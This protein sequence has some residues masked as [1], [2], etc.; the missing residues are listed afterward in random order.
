MDTETNDLKLKETLWGVPVGIFSRSIN[1]KSL[2]QSFEKAHE[3]ASKATRANCM[4]RCSDNKVLARHCLSAPPLLVLTGRSPKYIALVVVTAVVQSWNRKKSRLASV[5]SSS[6][7]VALGWFWGHS[8]QLSAS[9]FLQSP[10]L[11]HRLRL[12]CA[13]VPLASFLQLVRTKLQ[14]VVQRYVSGQKSTCLLKAIGKKRGLGDDYQH[15][16]AVVLL[17]HFLIL[18]KFD[19]EKFD[20]DDLHGCSLYVLCSIAAAAGGGGGSASSVMTAV[21]FHLAV[22]LCQVCNSTN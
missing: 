10:S 8:I 18:R 13:Q 22:G 6:T 1:P 2:L 5:I 4:P 15:A 21:A 14:H 19:S 20:L 12:W 17:S 11:R 7:P 16:S 3:P 9:S